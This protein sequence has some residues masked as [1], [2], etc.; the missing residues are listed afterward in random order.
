MTIRLS[1]Q[2]EATI[3]EKIET[4]HYRDAEEVVHAAL[5]LLNKRD[6]GI[7]W[8]NAELQVGIDQ[9]DRGESAEL[10]P[11]LV[12]D[13]KRRARQEAGSNRRYKVAILP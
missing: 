3:R 2:D 9:L 6:D 10:T 4:G 7:A 12:E 11:E 5:C 13:I 1:E 8:L